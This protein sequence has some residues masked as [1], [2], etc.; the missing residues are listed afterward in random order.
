MK[1]AII[2]NGYVGKAT[3]FLFTQSNT[4]GLN[5]S[6]FLSDVLIYDKDEQKTK[7]SFE[8]CLEADLFFVCVPTPMRRCGSWDLSYVEDVIY[9]LTLNGVQSHQIILRSTVPVGTCD[10]FEINFFPEFLTEA[11]WQEDIESTEDW[12]IGMPNSSY[13]LKTIL[14]KILTGRIHF[15]LNKEA[16][17]VKY[18]RNCFLATKVSFFNEINNFCE[19]NR[20]NYESARKLITL[21]PRIDESHTLVPGP[22][23][24]KGFG[25]TCFPKDMHS[26]KFQMQYTETTSLIIEAAI[27]RNELIDRPEK[28]WFQNKGRA[29]SDE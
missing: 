6:D 15:C 14:P 25:G 11:N 24:K 1:I 8:E 2:G 7:C 5:N 21:D 17:L 16:E 9:K 29:V 20:V 10:R 12:I 19:K 26:F 13:G 18:V 4:E 27:N 22:D 28:D 3:Q 23:G